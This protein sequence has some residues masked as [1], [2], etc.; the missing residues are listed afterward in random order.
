MANINAETFWDVSFTL[1]G[2]A[3]KIDANTPAT[4]VLDPLVTTVT[5]TPVVISPDGST[6]SFSATNTAAGDVTGVLTFDKNL[7]A[8]TL[9]LSTNVTLQF[10]ASAN[11]GA[12]TA[13]VVERT[14]V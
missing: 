3:G 13:V 9:D 6:A 1:A 5:A 12:D 4:L 7:D 14:V 2:A 10:V 11:I 8:G